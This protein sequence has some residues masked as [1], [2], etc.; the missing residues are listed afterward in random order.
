MR[1]Q[2]LDLIKYGHFTDR[3]FP[4]PAGNYDFHIVF[5]PNEAGKSTALAAIEDMLFGIPSRSSYNFLHDFSSMR[6]GAVLENG[7]ASLEVRRR[8]GNKDTLLDINDLPVAGGEGVLRPYLAGADRSFFERMF[9]LDHIRLQS[10]GKEILEAKD[11][12]GQ[13]LFSAGAGIAGL[14][15]RLAELSAE[16]DNLWSARRASHRKFYIASDK[17]EHAEKTLREQ[18]LTANKWR[19]LKRAYEEAEETYAKVAKKIE[20]H[21]TERQ[22]LNRIHR[23]FRDVR[24]KQELDNQLAALGDVITLPEDAAT[25]MEKAERGDTEAKTRIATLK[26]QLKLAEEALTAL[27]FDETLVQRAKD[28]GQLHE[29]RIE[30]RREKADLPKR[31]AELNAEEEVLRVH[32]SELAWVETGSEALIARI[33]P[34]AKVQVVRSLLKHKGTM[35]T[36]VTSHARELE[37]SQETLDNLKDQLTEM[38]EPVD[39]SRLA[40]VI[41]TLREKGDL[42]GQVRNAEQMFKDKQEVVNRKCKV[43]HPGEMDEET[44]TNMTVPAQAVVQK[45][46]EREHDWERRLRE[47]QQ[48][49]LSVQQ[50]LE[51]T[52]AEFDRRARDEHVVTIEDLDEAR[53]HRNTLWELLK[54]KH[55]QGEPILENQANGFEEYLED[56]AGAFE[57]AMYSSDNLAD[58]RFDHAEAA[59]QL[60]EIKRKIEEQTLLLKQTKENTTRLVEEGE[61]LQKAWA[62]IWD[63]AP[64]DPLATETML[65]WLGA[66]KDVLEALAERDNAGN[67]LETLRNEELEARRQVLNELAALGVDVTALKNDN[68]NVIIGHAAEEQHLRETE[69]SEKAQMEADV[70]DATE[71]VAR[72]KRDLHKAGESLGEWTKKWSHAIGELGLAK[73]TATEAVEIQIEVIEQMRETAR[74]IRSLRDERIAKINRNAANFEQVVA[75]LVKDLAEDLSDQSGE[76]AVLELEERLAEAKRVQELRK[77]KSKEAEGLTTQIADLELERREMAA[78]ISHLKAEAAVETNEALKEAIERSDQQRDLERQRQQIIEHLRQ[79]GDGKSMEELVE[80]CKDAVLDEIVAH[81]GSI[82]EELKDLQKQQAAAAEE[83]S[84]ARKAFQEVGGDDAAAQAEATKQEALTEI[85]DVAKQ[86]VRVRT[87]AMLLQWAIDRY[88]REKQAPLLNRAGE[89]FRIVTGDSFKS[90][91]VGFDDKDNAFLTGVRPDD[92]MVPVSGMSTGTADQLYL[93]LRI[94]S[95]EDYLER[96]EALPFV[97]D[98]LFINFD[99]ERAAAGFALLGELSQMTQVLFFT[100]HQHLVDIAQESLGDSV[101][102]VTLSD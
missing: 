8:K 61:Q 42:A 3:S 93:A 19:E 7:S 76:H 71:E 69:A 65:E 6:I 43:L 52:V 77:T 53:S 92:S 58:R 51:R 12:V 50:E 70:E 28:I 40:I 20:E 18:T 34:R 84:L 30:I 59:G 89:L 100:H 67:T 90:L 32:A 98:D 85:Q 54:R 56:L 37:T 64:F 16:A 94:A 55:V 22:R 39:V 41:K 96:A 101:S 60:A 11:D 5:G 14:R 31:E 26:E 57:P 102:I 68:L 95:I 47:A 48:K 44:L 46:R 97:A 63:S 23:V 87:S 78:S 81:D 73:D 91:Q 33:P 29:R 25:V 66:R 86:Y 72:R 36:D 35:E 82:Q 45:H 24:T 79:D 75:E 88:R 49:V 10:G 4:L 38:G 27:T 83:R 21:T 99:N 15:E 9:S 17:L 1:L 74:T 80:E 13:M 62:A 2:R